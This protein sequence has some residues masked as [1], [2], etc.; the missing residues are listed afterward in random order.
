MIAFSKQYKHGSLEDLYALCWLTWGC[1]GCHAM[2]S[3]Q[4]RGSKLA[5]LLRK[6]TVPFKLICNRSLMKDSFLQGALCF[7][8]LKWS[9]VLMDML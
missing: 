1:L 3:A 7:I 5:E 2:Q 8:S 4:G 6:R 9:Y